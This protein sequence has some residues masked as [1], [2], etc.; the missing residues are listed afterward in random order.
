MFHGAMIKETENLVLL[1]GITFAMHYVFRWCYLREIT[2]IAGQAEIQFFG[3]II[4]KNPWEY[5]ILVQVIVCS[6]C[7][8]QKSKLHNHCENV[9]K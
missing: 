7:K 2:I 9:P 1:Q 5:R 3:L 4:C 8:K 6:T